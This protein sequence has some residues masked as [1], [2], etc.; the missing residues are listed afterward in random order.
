MKLESGKCYCV[1]LVG[2]SIVEFKFLGNLS[3]NSNE[4]F[5]QLKDGTRASLAKLLSKG[6]HAY[7]DIDCNELA[8]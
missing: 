6:Y 3:E 1:L 2:D 5:V 7:W 8:N 4:V